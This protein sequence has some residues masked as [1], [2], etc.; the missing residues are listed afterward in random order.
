MSFYRMYRPTVIDEVDNTEI[1]KRLH[2]LL[3]KQPSDLPHAYLLTGPK[4]TG[5]T[6]SARI[7]AKLFVCTNRTKH[8]PCGTC[9][10]CTSVTTGKNMDVLEMDA[11]SNRGIEEIRQLKAGIALAPISAAYK[12]YIIDEVHM[13][14]TDA[15]NALLKTLEEPP[16][17]AVFILA[18][19]DPQKVLPT[20][21]SRCMELSFAKAQPDEL[22]SAL[23]RII[24]SEHMTIDDGAIERIIELADGAYRDAVKMLEQMSLVSKPITRA[25]VDETLSVPTQSLRNELFTALFQKDISK[26][27]QS[28]STLVEM[29]L[30][31]RVFVSDCAVY[32]HSLLLERF[33]PGKSQDKHMNQFSTEELTT[34]ADLF[35]NVYSLLR[36]SP[37]A[38]LPLEVA[39]VNYCGV[40]SG[41]T[42]KTEQP[43]EKKTKKSQEEAKVA[44]IKQ[45]PQEEDPV[46]EDI[47]A[48]S[49]E[50]TL[51]KLKT[52]WSDVIEAMK[53]FNNSVSGVLRST[54]PVSTDNGMIVIE[55]FYPFHKDRLS[56]AKVRDTLS[57]VFKKLFG[58]TVGIQ[59]ILGKK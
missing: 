9:D 50:L 10:Q 29:G 42:K 27:L 36:V 15:F 18:T 8:G 14:T 47:P 56:D 49:V 4:G 48:R 38:Q 51:E 1:K 13:L 26:A 31:V 46:F 39:L 11:A 33:I 6:T 44:Q 41:G 35:T 7:I 55:A 22:R 30:D 12:V 2:E 17:H 23:S 58:V 54:R 32:V 37:V 3:S 59:I 53:P 25:L 24:A 40:K 28:V 43:D 57:S 21:K 16:A 52:H 45:S 34:L 5:K 20:I 19:T